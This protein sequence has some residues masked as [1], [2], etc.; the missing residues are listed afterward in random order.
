M[1][2]VKFA[3]YKP[4]NLWGW[5]IAG[6][7]RLFN[8]GMPA[9]CHAEIGF[10]VDESLK[11]WFAEKG[12]AV[13]VDEFMYYSSSSRNKDGTTGTRWLTEKVLLAHPERWDIVDVESLRPIGHMINNCENELGKEYDWLGIYGFATILGLL[14]HKNKWYCSEVCHY[15]FFGIWKK[16]ISPMALYAK[17]KRAG[18]I[19]G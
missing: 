16:R 1:E 4:R 15:I 5:L 19:V 17:I 6:W 10:K 7:T 14:N 12:I 8:W 11:E 3:F 13:E 2:I 18:L 9:Y